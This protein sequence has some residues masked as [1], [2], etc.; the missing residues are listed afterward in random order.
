MVFPR[1][2]RFPPKDLSQCIHK[3][4]DFPPCTVRRT[5]EDGC[6]H[7]NFEGCCGSED[8]PVSIN[9]NLSR[10]LVSNLC[11]NIQWTNQCKIYK[12]NIFFYILIYIYIYFLVFRSISKQLKYEKL[13]LLRSG[14]ARPVPRRYSLNDF[15]TLFSLLR[16]I[17]EEKTR[18]FL[19]LTLKGLITLI[20]PWG[21][22][23]HPTRNKNNV[24]PNR[25]KF[26]CL[27]D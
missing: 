8:P 14:L 2:I 12:Y 15:F 16:S 22:G 10:H 24:L 1:Y 11:I 18:R 25:S 21:G 4:I 6:M 17:T 26:C 19:V 23:A 27:F 13:V 20:S 9:I 7:I 3:Y 5:W